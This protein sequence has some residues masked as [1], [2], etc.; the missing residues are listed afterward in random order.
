[1]L[2]LITAL[3]LAT[4]LSVNDPSVIISE[5]GTKTILIKID[6]PAVKGSIEIT[7][8]ANQRARI[9]QYIIT[10]DDNGNKKEIDITHSIIVMDTLAQ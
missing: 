8:L 1:M 10:I 6:N 4:G 2:E 5:N 9:V 7:K 3:L